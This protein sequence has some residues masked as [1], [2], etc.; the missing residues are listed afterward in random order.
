M[1]TSD[2]TLSDAGR[3]MGSVRSARKTAAARING[4]LGGRPR[5]HPA[6]EPAQPRQ[7]QTAQRGTLPLLI[8]PRKES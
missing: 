3:A 1:E 6:P 8:V 7:A 5:N 4:K 2:K